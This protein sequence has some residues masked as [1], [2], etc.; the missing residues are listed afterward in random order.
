MI[1]KHKQLSTIL[2]CFYL[3][4]SIGAEAQN[5]LQISLDSCIKMAEGNYPLQTHAQNVQLISNNTIKQINAEY[6]PQLNFA[7]KA[8]YQSEVSEIEIPGFPLMSIPKDNYS[9]G[10]E[11]NQIICDFGQIAQKKAVQRSQAISDIQKNKAELYVIRPV[12]VGMYSNILLTKK[13]IKILES[14]IESIQNQY[15]DMQSAVTNGMVLQS[16]LDI[17]FAEIQKTRQRL[18]EARYALQTQVQTLALYTQAAID[19][20]TVL[21]PINRSRLYLDNDSVARPELLVFGTQLD[22]LDEKIKL[23]KRKNM[24]HLY[25]YGEGAYGRPGYNFLDHDMRLFGIAGVGL[26]WNMNGMYTHSLS[27]NSLKINKNMMAE[28]KSLFQLHQNEALIK[29]HNEIEKLAQ[30]IETDKAILEKRA[31][32]ANTAADQLENGIITSTDF[33]TQLY[34]QKQAELSQQLHEIQLQMAVINYN[35]TE[36]TN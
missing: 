16:N 21:E 14:Y 19:T 28:Q 29:Q 1:Q 4:T 12:I 11:L 26:R 23:E 13:N 22:L 24:P 32:I 17:L 5:V 34:A 9:F 36:G 35:I 6:L 18:I 7:S 10:L 2:I 25:L 20:A 15:K 33:L 3:F 8:T 27:G 31:N 30:L